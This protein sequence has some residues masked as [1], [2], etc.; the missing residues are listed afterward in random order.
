MDRQGKREPAFPE[1]VP[2]GAHW[3]PQRLAWAAAV[4]PAMMLVTAIVY[5]TGGTKFIFPHLGYVPILLAAFAFGPLGGAVSGIGMGL[6]LGPVMPLDVAAVLPQPLLNWM[7]R[8]LLFAFFGV[9]AGSLAMLFA[10][11]RAGEQAR[12]MSD[13]LLG[14]PTRALLE[15]CAQTQR[16]PTGRPMR[17]VAVAAVDFGTYTE[18]ARVLGEGWGDEIVQ[19]IADALRES[20]PDQVLAARLHRDLFVILVGVSIGQ[21]RPLLRQTIENF[22]RTVMVESFRVPLR[23]TIGLAHLKDTDL[24]TG[25]VFRKALFALD[26]ARTRNRRIAHYAARDDRRERENFGLLN[27]L[28]HD[29]EQGRLDLHYQPQ[30]S[31]REGRMAGMEALIRWTRA[32][33]GPV[34]PGRFIPLAERTGLID[35]ITYWTIEAAT[36]R[37]AEWHKA[38][39]PLRMAINLSVRNLD[40]E[41]LL[42]DLLR[43]PRRHGID[44]SAIEF[45]VTETAAMLD[46]DATRTFLARLRRAGFR[47]ALDDFG[48][49]HSSLSHLFELPLDVLKIDQSFVRRID[50]DPAAR[51]IVSAIVTA[52]H[53]LGLEVVAEGVETATALAFVTA[54][55][56]DLVQGYHLA[57]PMSAATLDAWFRSGAANSGLGLPADMPD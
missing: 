23:P 21:W 44:P 47:V 24:G 43:L 16:D 49:G 11:F 13:P 34:S 48:T 27:D 36:R 28:R 2:F 7:S 1:P 18:V 8:L 41:Y 39:L 50:R 12:Q 42:A 6:L 57:R 4:L 22:P 3:V 26:R 17:P 52:G 40:S 29:L 19:R 51:S 38:G 9:L 10:R 37:L 31:L 30:Y 15:L 55:G 5:E 35:D 53:E 32:E 45:E 33:H 56:C 25:G 20:L 54:A 14:L 46:L